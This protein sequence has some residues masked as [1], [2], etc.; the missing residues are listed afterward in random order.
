MRD[1]KKKLIMAGLLAGLLITPAVVFAAV[2]YSGERENRF[3][4]AKGDIQV[5][6]SNAENEKGEELTNSFVLEKNETDDNYST[7][8]LVQIYDERSNSGESLRV[9]FIPMWYDADGNVCGGIDG[10]T[11]IS[12]ISLD[13]SASKL[14]FYTGT[15]DSKAPAVTVYLAEGY[16]SSWEYKGDGCFYYSGEVRDDKTTP[17]LAERVEITKAVYDSTADCELRLDVLADAIQTSGNA[18][19]DREWD[20]YDPSP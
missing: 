1:K 12:E 18:Y 3:S 17:L 11:D 14:I 5:L 2:Y 6:E 19:S 15:G 20:G 4:P 16:D 13:Q 10:V 9:S 7:E 8:K